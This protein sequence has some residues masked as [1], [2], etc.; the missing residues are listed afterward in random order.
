MR[1]QIELSNFDEAIFFIING[2]VGCVI[3]SS[4]GFERDAFT[5][6][7]PPFIAHK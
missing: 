2:V 3:S 4:V 6:V 1:V 5:H 7:T